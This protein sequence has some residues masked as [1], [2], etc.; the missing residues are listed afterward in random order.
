MILNISRQVVQRERLSEQIAADGFEPSYA[1]PVMSVVPEWRG[2]QARSPLPVTSTS[3]FGFRLVAMLTEWLR[4]NLTDNP[5]SPVP[6]QWISVHQLYIDYQLQ[7]GELGPV[8]HSKR[9]IDTYQ[10]PQFRLNPA[11]FKKRS[12]WFGRVLRNVLLDHGCQPHCAVTR[13]SSTMLALHVQSL[14][15]PWPIWRLEAVEVWLSHRLSRAAT[16]DGS[17]LGSLP[18]AKQDSSFPSLVCPESGPFRP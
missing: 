4:Q 5:E 17:S 1:K 3:K 12:T 7:T 13:P 18:P 2:F 11:G 9:W 10:R 15:L 8:N 14:A 16:R 6:V